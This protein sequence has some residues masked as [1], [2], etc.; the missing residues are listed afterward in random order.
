MTIL[1][2][3]TKVK[4]TRLSLVSKK[5]KFNSTLAK[6]ARGHC[7]TIF[8]NRLKCIFL[9]VKKTVQKV[10]FHDPYQIDSIGH[11]CN[12]LSCFIYI[13]NCMLSSFFGF[14]LTLYL[15]FITE[16]ENFSQSECEK[17]YGR[18]KF[19]TGNKYVI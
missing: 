15:T 16:K 17:F 7:V 19:F 2:S 4:D 5:S 12:C 6:L 1:T 3:S 18:L 9:G 8:L 13:F 10:F 14:C 11:V